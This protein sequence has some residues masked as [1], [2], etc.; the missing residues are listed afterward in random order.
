[1]KKQVTLSIVH[2]IYLTKDERYSIHSGKKIT[3]VGC[4]LPVW[5]YQGDTSEPAEEVFCKYILTNK[6]VKKN[7]SPVEIT[8][9]G[10]KI[11]LPQLPEGY[12]EPDSLT[13]EEW[14]KMTE[15]QKSDWYSKNAKP[16][17]SENLL[18]YADGG[19]KSLT[20]KILEVRGLIGDDKKVVK[21]YEINIFY[22]ILIK[23][24]DTFAES[25]VP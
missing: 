10:Y 9:Q 23:D 1:M 17:T 13:N 6:K 19:S 20:F 3:V 12:K 24:F 16:I 25:I 14:R 22:I 2:N 4:S 7:I 21:D 8:K 11:N 15:K 18:D 5:F